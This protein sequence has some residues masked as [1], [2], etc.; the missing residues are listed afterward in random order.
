MRLV[1]SNRLEIRG[2]V[3]TDFLHVQDEFYAAASEWYLAGKLRCL[4]D[5]YEGLDAAPLAFIGMLKGK[6]FGKVLVHIAH[7]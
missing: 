6:N 7:G 2:F 1:L 3:M 5:I 4:E